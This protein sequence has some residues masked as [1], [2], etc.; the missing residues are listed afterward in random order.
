MEYGVNFE[1][2]VKKL[3]AENRVRVQQLYDKYVD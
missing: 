2:F 3:P 1:A